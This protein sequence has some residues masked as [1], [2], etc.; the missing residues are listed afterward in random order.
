MSRV[1]CADYYMVYGGVV[2]YGT[3]CI[4][5]VWCSSYRVL[6]GAGCI[7]YDRYSVVCV[8]VCVC[9]WLYCFIS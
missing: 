7:L 9:V 1:C 5:M 2:W 4:D 8:Y 6:C 3:V